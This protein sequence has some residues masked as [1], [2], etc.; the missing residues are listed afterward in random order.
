MEPRPMPTTSSNSRPGGA[1]RAMR[2][3]LSSAG[4]QPP[5]LGYLNAHGTSTPTNDRL[6]TAAIKAAL[7][8]HAAALPISSIKGAI[9]HTLGAGGA[10]E[11]AI[12]VMVLQTG[13][14]PPTI[15]Y[16]TPD[17]DCDLDYVPNLSRDL[18]TIGAV[19]TNSM[20]FGGHNASV[21]FTHPEAR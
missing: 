4:L 5:D 2:L 16:R 9:G 8:E 7:C 1:A 18:G 20:G 13:K 17:P 14:A 15:N 21:V 6:E 3:A 10:V 19:M 12:S 11:A